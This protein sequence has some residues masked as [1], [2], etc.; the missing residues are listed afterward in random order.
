MPQLWILGS[1]DYGAQLAAHFGLPYSYAYFFDDGRGVE[2]ALGFYRQLYQPSAQ[3]PRPLAAR[4]ELEEIVIN[5]WT[6]DPAA[7]AHSCELLAAALG[8][9]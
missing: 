7:R 4:L 5:T 1:S 9:S 3:Y 8:C 6:Y 2:R